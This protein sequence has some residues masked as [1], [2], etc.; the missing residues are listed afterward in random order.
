M[1]KLRRSALWLAVV[2]AAGV[3]LTPQ[4]GAADPYRLYIPEEQV[5]E[6]DD[7]GHGVA[8]RTPFELIPG[9]WW[10]YSFITYVSSRFV[11]NS[12]HK[13]QRAASS[14]RGVAR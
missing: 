7:G 6:P 5:G 3:V 11:A 4:R 2:I 9:S 1:K 13:D 12:F 14:S 10:A 8:A